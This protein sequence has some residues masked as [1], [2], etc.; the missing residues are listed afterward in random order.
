MAY[1]CTNVTA[2]TEIG[3]FADPSIKTTAG[4][5]SGNAAV[6]F[7]ARALR[8]TAQGIANY[9]VRNGNPPPVPSPTP[10]RSPSPA[11]PRPSP[12]P[13]N[14]EYALK[15]NR[16]TGLDTAVILAVLVQIQIADPAQHQTLRML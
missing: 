1:Q 8:E 7:C 13:S 15:F 3:L 14:C 11:S 6:G 2:N 9:R 10:G 5:P 4:I 16:G 12:P